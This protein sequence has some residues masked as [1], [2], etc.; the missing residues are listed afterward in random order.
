M[1]DETEY[2]KGIVVENEALNS[3]NI[4]PHEFHGEW[5]FTIKP[6]KRKT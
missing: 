6:T 4:Y 2:E 1:L 3:V 5:N